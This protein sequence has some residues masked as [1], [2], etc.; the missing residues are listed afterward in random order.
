MI[1]ACTRA[2]LLPCV[3]PFC[4]KQLFCGG[5]Q[6]GERGA[7]W[8][9]IQPNCADAEW[10]ESFPVPLWKCRCF[11]TPVCCHSP[12]KSASG[13]RFWKAQERHDILCRKADKF[14]LLFQ[15]FSFLTPLSLIS[16]AS[17]RCFK[18]KPKSR[19]P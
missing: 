18:S 1:D 9:L 17:R 15:S 3:P 7:V 19:Y 8:R 11:P 4:G 12:D 10:R 16:N 14:L 2:V 5:N 13:Y 6:N